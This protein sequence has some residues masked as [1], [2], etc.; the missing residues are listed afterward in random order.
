MR[1]QREQYSKTIR[2]LFD[3]IDQESEAITKAAQLMSEAIIKD[4]LIHVIGS[5]GHSNIGA[6][7]IFRRAGGLV[8]VNAVLDP[9]TL[10]NFG[11]TRSG[12]IERTPGYAKPVLDAFEVFS[13]VLIIVN[14]YGINAVTI[15]SALEGKR[16][17]IPTIGVTSRSFGDNVPKDHPARH[18]SGKNLY[19]LVD[20]FVDCHMPYGDA[21]IE[22]EGLEQKVAPVSSLLFSYTLNLMVIETVAIMLEK[23]EVP[24]IWTSGNMP[25]GDQKNKKFKE[26]YKGR[27]RLM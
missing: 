26:M 19:E 16:R 10:V 2:S 6:F 13:G 11:A 4:E 25:G 14:P 9:G 8:Q 5:G 22:F 24:K 23:G 15:D 17:G 21:V 1:L 7:E 3:Q 20:V 18:P 27:I 12:L